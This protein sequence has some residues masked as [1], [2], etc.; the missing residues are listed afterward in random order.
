MAVVVQ[1]PRLFTPPLRDLSEPDASWG[2]DV[3]WFAREILG[4]PL[5][6]WQEWLMIHALEVLTRDKAVEFAMLEDSPE[7][8]LAKIERLYGPPLVRG[9][10]PIPNGRLR[11]TKIV[12]L[13]S[14]QNGKTFMVKTLLKWALFR[15]RLPEVLAAAQTLNKSMALWDEVKRE[16]EDNPKLSRLLG[17][18]MLRNGSQEFWTKGRKDERSRY[19]PVGIDENAGRGDTVDL[20]YIDELR[21]Q[22]TFI[23]VNALSATTTV[24]DNGLIVTTSNAG[25]AHSVVLREYRRLAMAPITEGTWRDT[26]QGLFEWSA[27]PAADIDD[28]EGWKQANPDLGHGRITLATLRAERES[29]PEATFRTERLCQWVEELGEDFQPVIDYTR[30]ESLAVAGDVRISQHHVLAVEVSADGEQVAVVAAGQTTRG[31]HLMA[32]PLRKFTVDE[33][34]DMV[35]EFNASLP[36]GRRL[37]AVA[38][39]KDSPASVLMSPLKR[40]GI[41]PTLLSGGMV[42]QAWKSFRAAVADGRITHDGA[43]GW[44]AALRVARERSSEKFPSLER[45]SGEISTLVAGTFAAWAL[46]TYIAEFEAGARRAVETKQTNPLGA[47]PKFKRQRSSRIG[48]LVSA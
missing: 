13:I 40:A 14:R 30:W 12:I 21:T 10:R 46:D 2:H 33:V 34:V 38:I 43:D 42:S 44:M 17:D 26:R 15:K 11:F 39:D 24:P 16:V 22:K 19:R 1:L 3:V 35:V 4:E 29:S 41:E 25:S 36:I 20:L 31:V 48:G 8:E 18:V 5:A 6:P 28:V 27:D 47:F 7:A 32:L 9:G 23:G 37:A 45:Y